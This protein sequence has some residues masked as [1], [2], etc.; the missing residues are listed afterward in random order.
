[1]T[2]ISSDEENFISTQFWKNGF[3]NWS[4]EQK[5]PFLSGLQSTNAKKNVNNFYIKIF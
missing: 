2:I 3:Q 1:M 4:D 5:K